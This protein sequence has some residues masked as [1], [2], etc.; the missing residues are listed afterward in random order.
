[1]KTLDFTAEVKADNTLSVPAEVADQVRDA[2][3]VRVVIILPDPDEDADWRRL[4]MERFLQGYSEADAL[5][6][7]LPPR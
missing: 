2:G 3:A 4:G 1:M 6:D 7:E 5:Y